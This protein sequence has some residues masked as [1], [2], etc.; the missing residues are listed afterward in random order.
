MCEY[1]QKEACQSQWAS[2]EDEEEEEEEVASTHACGVALHLVTLAAFGGVLSGTAPVLRLL[3][4]PLK[5]AA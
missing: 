3:P 1:G 2:V 4:L 5:L